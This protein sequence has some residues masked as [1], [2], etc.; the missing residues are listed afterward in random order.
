[1][2][3]NQWNIKENHILKRLLRNIKCAE[4]FIYKN[5]RNALNIDASLAE[6][7]LQIHNLHMLHRG[8]ESNGCTV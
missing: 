3:T 5:K 7:I 6:N 1:M 8:F 2:N 4:G